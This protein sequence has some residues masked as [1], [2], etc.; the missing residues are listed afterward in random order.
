MQKLQGILNH[1]EVV[2]DEIIWGANLKP[3]SWAEGY[4]R[5]PTLV[6]HGEFYSPTP[7]LRSYGYW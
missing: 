7:P 1:H 6:L 5:T 3:L 4:S 2:L